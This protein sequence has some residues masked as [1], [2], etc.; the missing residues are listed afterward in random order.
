M[1]RPR[2]RAGAVDDL[3]ESTMES[4]VHIPEMAQGRRRVQAAKRLPP[5]APC[6]CVRDPDHDRHRCHGEMTLPMADGL[7]AAAIPLREYGLT[8]IFDH[9]SL[10]AAWKLCPEYRTAIEVE[11]MTGSEA[12]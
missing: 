5:L 12:A 6:G 7:V 2:H 8:P 10:R 4:T 1:T 3:E 9:Q 11:A